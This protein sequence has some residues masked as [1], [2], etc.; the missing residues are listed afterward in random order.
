VQSF[1]AICKE[2]KFEYPICEWNKHLFPWMDS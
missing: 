2:G 1:Q